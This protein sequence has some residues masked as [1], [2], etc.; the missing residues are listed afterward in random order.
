MNKYILLTSAFIISSI[1]SVSAQ[2][3]TPTATITPTSA[4]T[5]T[6]S[7]LKSA[8]ATEVILLA[9]INLYNPTIRKTG[10]VNYTFSF[11]LSSSDLINQEAYYRAFL[12]DETGK[13]VFVQTFPTKVIVE[14]GKTKAVS[15]VLIVPQDFKGK[16]SAIVQVTNADGLPLSSA[17]LGTI[18]LV[19]GKALFD[20]TDCTIAGEKEKTTSDK[21]EGTC[22]VTGKTSKATVLYTSLFYGNAAAPVA[23]VKSSVVKGTAT[24]AIPTTLNPGVYQIISQ[25]Y[26]AGS[27]VSSP[28]FNSVLVKGQTAKV[29]SVRTDKGLYK[30]EESARVSVAFDAVNFAQGELLA[31]VKLETTGKDICGEL[32]PSVIKGRSAFVLTVP[33]TRKCSTPTVTVT[34][35]DK[36]GKVF[37]TY[38]SV[39]VSTG[40]KANPLFSL[41]NMTYAGIA[42]VVIALLALLFTYVRRLRMQK[43][44]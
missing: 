42:L 26:D 43:V 1:V 37:D 38:T 18:D 13:I 12:K 4:P 14:A 6:R 36:T 34:L 5:A 17:N 16:Y 19:G 23:Q 15:D 33:I 44:A 11:T 29:V 8:T 41:I 9:G 31:Q 10:L 28:V 3:A 30:K 40:E 22:K 20:V 35:Q 21:I 32:A 39:V 24:F 7:N 25:L 2:N 27:P